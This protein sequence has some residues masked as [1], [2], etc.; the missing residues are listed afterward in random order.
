MDPTLNHRIDRQ[1]HRNSRKLT[2]T[3]TQSRRLNEPDLE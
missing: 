2:L 3:E 1:P